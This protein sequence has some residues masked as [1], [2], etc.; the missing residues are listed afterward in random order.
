VKLGQ[1]II[2]SPWPTKNTMPI[3][4]IGGLVPAAITLFLVNPLVD[5]N[6]YLK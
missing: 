6:I 1:Y 4:E 3:I 5:S 2:T